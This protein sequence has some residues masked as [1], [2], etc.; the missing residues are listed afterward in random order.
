MTRLLRWLVT[1]LGIGLAMIGLAGSLSTTAT[2]P[3]L[4]LV[5]PSAPHPITEVVTVEVRAANVANL[6]A[7]EFD[8]RYDP[9]FL[10]LVDM[11]IAPGFGAEEKCTPQ[12]QRCAIALGPIVERAGRAEV[13]AIT[14]GQPAG[15]TGEAT[16][17][18]LHLR[19]ASR[20]GKTGLSLENALLADINAKPSTPAVRGA[21]LTLAAASFGTEQQIYLPNVQK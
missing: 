2:T 18:L 19:P 1:S 11:R 16:I 4:Y 20:I 5:A 15:L 6:G 7:W 13:G 14:Y 10:T 17:A 3:T 21:T 12:K 8:L 9:A